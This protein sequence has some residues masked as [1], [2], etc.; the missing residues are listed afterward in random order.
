M[1]NLYNRIAA[2]VII[3]FL[4]T[5]TANAVLA[6]DVKIGILFGFTG[7][8]ESMTPSMAAAA[9]LAIE[10]INQSGMF[11]GGGHSVSSVRADAT[12]ID[13]AV[14]QSAAERLILV[15]KVDAIVG[16]ACSGAT[17]AVL[18][19]V[20]LPNGVLLVSPSS[21]SP[22]LSSL[23]D[24]GLFFR[25]ASSGARNGQVMAEVLLE[26]G[27]KQVA[28]TYTNNDYG[29]GLADSFIQSYKDKGG[30]VTLNIAHEDNK[31]D[32]T[33]EVAALNS[34]GG[35][36]LVVAG[37][38][39]QGGAG[40]IQAALDTGAFDTFVLPDGMVSTSLEERFGSAIDG[41]FGQHSAN[42]SPGMAIMTELANANGFNAL[43]PFTPESYD[44]AAL[45]LLAMQAAGQ[46]DADAV[47]EK[48]FAVANAPGEVILPGELA[49]G[50]KILQSGGDIDYAGGGA[51]ELVAPGEND[52]SFREIEIKGGKITTVRYR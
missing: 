1:K 24:N 45:I 46:T 28:V 44:A 49:K 37:Y 12:C 21:T 36:V 23:K 47:K 26:R 51:I 7:P 42:N 19:N 8:V 30:T 48:I 43:S 11:L 38:A 27:I 52:G 40:I 31:A 25:T 29:I 39:D 35:E 4:I 15:E 16:A 41:S 33:A 6:K 5:L 13:S 10:E 50:L 22:A 32:Y 2:S 34:A 17:I 9:E 20:A 3:S 14:A 18:Q